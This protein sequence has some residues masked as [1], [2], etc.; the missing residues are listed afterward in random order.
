VFLDRP[1]GWVSHAKLTKQPG[2]LDFMPPEA[3]EDPP[4]YTVSVDAFSFGCVTIHL[5]THKWPTPIGKTAQGKVISELE[6]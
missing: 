3:L 6:R 4:K 1:G 5:C 2:T